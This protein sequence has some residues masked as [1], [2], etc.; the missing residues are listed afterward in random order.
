MFW[1]ILT[2]FIKKHFKHFLKHFPLSTTENCKTPTTN[3]GCCKFPFV[4]KNTPVNQCQ[5]MGGDTS[6]T[7]C[8]TTDNFD[9]DAQWGEC[10]PSGV[11]GPSYATPSPSGSKSATLY[12]Q[13]TLGP[14]TTVGP[15]TT[16]GPQTGPQS[17]KIKKIVQIK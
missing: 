7:W 16:I 12:P 8:A 2:F 14:Q 3:G 6:K 15:Q 1:I 11:A 4:H 5:P 17:K 13:T 9:R 10:V